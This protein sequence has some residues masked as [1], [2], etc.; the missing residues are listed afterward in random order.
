MCYGSTR[1]PAWSSGLTPT[2][3]VNSAKAIS[4]SFSMARPASPKPTLRK[5]SRHGAAPR[6]TIGEGERSTTFVK[7][8]HAPG[9]SALS[10]DEV[11]GS[12]RRQAEAELATEK[13]PGELKDTIKSYFLSLEKAK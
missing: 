2:M 5:S 13:I 12:Y 9:K 10:Q 6:V 1:A 7:A 4:L 3:M 8:K 11:I